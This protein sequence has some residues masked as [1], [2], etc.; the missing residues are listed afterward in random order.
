[1]LDPAYAAT[2]ERT[3]ITAAVICRFGRY[4]MAWDAA[5]RHERHR[6]TGRSG[7]SHEDM[8]RRFYPDA[9]SVEELTPYR[10]VE[11]C[12]V[13]IPGDYI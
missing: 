10:H 7:V 12:S 4:F 6:L 1:M 2:T 9:P 5:G 11:V 8:F 3:P 13:P